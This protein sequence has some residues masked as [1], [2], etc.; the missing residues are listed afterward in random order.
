VTRV[1]EING[2]SLEALA[3]VAVAI[4]VSQTASNVAADGANRPK[5]ERHWYLTAAQ[6]DAGD[7][8]GATFSGGRLPAGARILIKRRYGTPDDLGLVAKYSASGSGTWT[9]T[10]PA[11]P[12]GSYMHLAQATTLTAR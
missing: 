8:V 12:L 7:P 1:R 3:L 4:L 5:P 9:V 6:I 11:V 10:L 2:G